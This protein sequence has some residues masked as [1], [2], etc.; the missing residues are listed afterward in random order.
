MSYPK[1]PIGAEHSCPECVSTGPLLTSH[2]QLPD[3]SVRHCYANHYIWGSYAFG[4]D[5]EQTE[6]EAARS[7]RHKA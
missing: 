3:A 6:K 7:S 5:L 4:L 1:R 2:N